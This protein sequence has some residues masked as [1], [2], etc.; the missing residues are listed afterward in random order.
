MT[1]ACCSPGNPQRRIFEASNMST[2]LSSVYRSHSPPTYQSVPTNIVTGV[3]YNDGQATAATESATPSPSQT[4]GPIYLP[5]PH[6]F[7]S[8]L[9]HGLQIGVILIIVLGVIGIVLLSMW[10]CC[11]C[12]GL[13]P[14]R[15]RTSQPG[16]DN[17]RRRLQPR[18][19]NPNSHPL[20]TISDAEARRR[21]GQDSGTANEDPPPP[22]Y[23]E[24]PPPQHQT[25]A[26]GIT[27]VRD[28]EEG[29][30]SDG[31]T[32]LS[33][34]PFED[35]VLNHYDSGESGSGS[36]SSAREFASRHQGLGG[37]TTGHTNS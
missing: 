19:G 30:I 33:E 15:N 29:I 14:Q 21:A 1:S 18:R 35:V 6:G 32:P 17:P 4:H 25:I 8:H 13:R 5:K 11:G 23:Q 10:Y 34:I 28:E 7:W 22:Q 3:S 37:D 9:N 27:H 20:T 2:T 12:C 31:K 36:P 24:T 26:G 16:Q